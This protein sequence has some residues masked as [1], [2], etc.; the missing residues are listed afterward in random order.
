[1]ITSD[2]NY[3]WHGFVFSSE[4]EF[5]RAK[6]EAEGTKYMKAKTDIA[7]PQVVLQIYNRMVQ[8]QLFETA[9]GICYLH[10]LRQR[11]L[12][13]ETIPDEQIE[14]IIVKQWGNG[15]QQPK[16][17]T[18]SSSDENDD[19][20]GSARAAIALRNANDEAKEKEKRS[21]AQRF[22]II[23]NVM[24]ILCVIA[25]FIISMTGKSLTIVN[26]ENRLIDK[27]ESWEQ[28]L[29]EREAKIKQYEEE[30]HITEGGYSK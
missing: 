24:L 7:S 20:A 19:D 8:K 25:M 9:V 14:P 5:E 16:E 26:Y 13:D 22:S 18:A 12:D 23:L 2:Q 30:Y 28:Q 6:K 29:K 10:E 21:G 17:G 4:E 11:L 15:T 1:M 27:Y 3:E